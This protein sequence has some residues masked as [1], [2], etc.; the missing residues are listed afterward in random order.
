MKGIEDIKIQETYDKLTTY[1]RIFCY[2]RK[3]SYIS[4]ITNG[5]C[6][7]EDLVSIL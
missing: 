7:R 3:Q 4:Y 1:G 6:M 2:R 5:L